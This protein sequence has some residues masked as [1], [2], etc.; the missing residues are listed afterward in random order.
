[1]TDSSDEFEPA[2]VLD[3]DMVLDKAVQLVIR[4]S[5]TAPLVASIVTGY[6]DLLA[7]LLDDYDL[8]RRPEK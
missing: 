5:D 4:H 1:M 8:L 6:L 2:D 3:P 7:S